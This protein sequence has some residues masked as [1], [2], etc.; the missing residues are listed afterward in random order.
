[1]STNRKNVAG[2]T[3]LTVPEVRS[4]QVDI[5][6]GTSTVICAGACMLRG[7]NVNTT[8]NNYAVTFTNGTYGDETVPAGAYAG[9]WEPYGDAYF[10]DGLTATYDAAATGNI[11]VKYL[12]LE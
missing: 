7:V 5:S 2:Q 6:V 8:L 11:T 3:V 1:M 12:P 9:F 4:K 10:P